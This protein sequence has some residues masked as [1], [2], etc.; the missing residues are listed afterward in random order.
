MKIDFSIPCQKD[1]VIYD[2]EGSEPLI[3]EATAR[4]FDVVAIDTRLKRPNFIGLIGSLVRFSLFRQRF[5]DGYLDTMLWLHKPKVIL[6]IIDND[7]RFWNIRA[8]HSNI[9]TIAVQNGYRD[10]DDP[11]FSANSHEAAS[12]VTHLFAFNKSIGNA[13]SNAARVDNL[14]P[15]GSYRNNRIEKLD[16]EREG[17]GWISQFRPESAF[18]D[19][20]PSHAEFFQ[21]ET[22]AVRTFFKWAK[23]RDLPFTVLGS[24][25]GDTSLQEIRWF[26]RVLE[27]DDLRYVPKADLQAS[28]QR[29][30]KM[31]IVAN[32]SST[33]GYEALARGAKCVFF[34][35]AAKS[36]GVPSW[37]FGWPMT[38][39]VLPEF[40]CENTIQED[41]ESRLD[42]LMSFRESSVATGLLME[43][44]SGNSEFWRVVSREL[45]AT[46]SS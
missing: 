7:F 30:D 35:L 45:S 11:V 6:T 22:D 10:K 43:W 8:R 29:V 3:S 41:V 25:S 32:V 28:Y 1:L 23:S 31:Q 27:I 2:N 18:P 17:A 20:A 26:S 39:E 19:N 46:R 4:G 21:R 16:R 44:D 9:V 34:N 5:F 15:H 38:F 14:H 37:I 12:G 36:P 24:Q 33:L 40:V 42:N 13:F